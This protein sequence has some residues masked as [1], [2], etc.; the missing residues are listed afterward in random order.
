MDVPPMLYS[1]NPLP[2]VP[3]MVLFLHAILID[4][5]AGQAM[6]LGHTLVITKDGRDVL[7]RLTPDYHICT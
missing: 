5:D 2:A 6:S 3:G 7:S 4:A 1:G